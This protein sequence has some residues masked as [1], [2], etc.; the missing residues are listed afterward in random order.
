MSYLERTWIKRV[1]LLCDVLPIWDNYF[2]PA[3]SYY[4]TS[5]TSNNSV[6][7][8]STRI[9]NS[10]WSDLPVDVHILTWWHE[11]LVRCPVVLFWLKYRL[12][13]HGNYLFSLSNKIFSGSKHPH[14]TLFNFEKGSTGQMFLVTSS[15]D[16]N[17]NK[18]KRVD[19]WGHKD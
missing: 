5:E 2:N 4:G 18:S 19:G 8:F 16:M 3:I 6:N 7:I 1:T 17:I 15:Q 11:Q 10:C 13:H 12:P 14:T 9:V